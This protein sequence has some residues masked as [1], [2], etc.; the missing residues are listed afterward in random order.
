MVLDSLFDP[1]HFF[2][3]YHLCVTFFSSAKNRFL[4]VIRVLLLP[5]SST[6]Q[7]TR[8]TAH[9]FLRASATLRES[10]KLLAPKTHLANS[11][12]PELPF[13]DFGFLI[14]VFGSRE[15]RTL[16]LWQFERHLNPLTC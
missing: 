8:T 3:P 6:T 10:S 2:G 5:N 4:C 11:L 7:L 14:S 9:L 12:L 13:I 15:S 1:L 16:D